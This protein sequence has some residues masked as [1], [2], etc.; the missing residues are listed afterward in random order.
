MPKPYLFRFRSL[1]IAFERKANA[2][3]YRKQTKMEAADRGFGVVSR[4]CKVDAAR[5]RLVSKTTLAPKHCIWA[6]RIFISRL[7]ESG[8]WRWTQSRAN[9]SPPKLPANREKY[10]D[11]RAF[12]RSHLEITRRWRAL[13]RRGTEHW[14]PPVVVVRRFDTLTQGTRS[15]PK[16]RSLPESSFLSC[17]NRSKLLAQNYAS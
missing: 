2:P 7:I 4:A 6:V 16:N 15:L 11:L 10:R 12:D 1:G 3:S 14:T 5:R 17:Q 8:D 9:F 13:G